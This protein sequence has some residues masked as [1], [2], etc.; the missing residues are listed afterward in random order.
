MAVFHVN[1]G[2]RFTVE[3]DGRGPAQEAERLRKAILDPRPVWKEAAAISR[4]SFRANFAAG[5]RPT[6]WRPLRPNT[7]AQKS[8]I[9]LEAGFPYATMR[10]RR[11][12]R[13]LEQRGRRSLANILIA[14]GTLRDS[15]VQSSHRDHIERLSKERVE[16]G[17]KHWL[18]AYHEHGTDPYMIRPKRARS[19]R[20]ITVAGAVF[21]GSVQHPGLPARP[22]AIIQEEDADRVMGAMR[23]HLESGT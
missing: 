18:A 3:I 2:I 15:Y 19:L 17:S 14:D 8:H 9:G 21:A 4:A 13:R 20:F 10:G 1:R 23:R 22:V 6:P 12:V 5:G 11:R 7:V 16:V